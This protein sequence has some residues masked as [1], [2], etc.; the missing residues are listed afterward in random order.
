MASA[1]DAA[2]W[3]VNEAPVEERRILREMTHPR[4][5]SGAATCI[6]PY[7]ERIVCSIMSV[8][9]EYIYTYH[10]SMAGANA[11]E[12]E[13]SG[14]SS[15]VGTNRLGGVFDLLY[16][17]CKVR[18]Y[19]IVM[20]FFPHGVADVEPVFA[21]LWQHSSRREILYNLPQPA[22]TESESSGKTLVEQW[23]ELGKF[24]L[25]RPGC[26][27]EGAAVML[28]RLLSRKDTADSVQPAFINWAVHEIRDA[29]GDGHPLAAAKVNSKKAGLSIASVLRVNGALRVLCHLF[30]VIDSA[31]ALEQQM[32]LLT[33]I[34]QLDAFDQHSLTGKL[35]TKAVQRLAILMLPPASIAAEGIVHNTGNAE[36]SEE[37]ELFIG[38]LLQKLHDKDTIVRWSAAKGVGRVAERLPPV[39]AQEIVLAVASILKEEALIPEDGGLIDVS[40]T[41]EFSWHG[42]LLA[43]AELSRKGLLL[44]QAL[45]EIVPWV[46]RGLTYEI[47][48]GDYSVGSNVRDAACYV[49]WSFA[50]SPNPD[51]RNVF[52]EMSTAMA[53]TLISVAV[54]DRESNVRRAASAAFQEHVGRHNSFLMEYRHNLPLGLAH[55]RTGSCCFASASPLAPEYVIYNLLPDIV[56]NTLSPFLAVR[57]GAIVATGVIAETIAPT[58]TTSEHIQKMILSVTSSL[59]ARYT[60]D[61]GAA[62]TLEALSAYMGS[63]SRAKWSIGG[64]EGQRKYFDYFTRAFTVCKEAQCLVSSF[65][66]FVDA[67]GVSAEQHDISGPLP[68]LPADIGGMVALSERNTAAAASALLEGLLDHAVDNRGDVGSWVRK[69]C[70]LSLAGMFESD[71]ALLSKLSADQ[72]LALCLF[73][74]SLHAATEKIDKIRLAAG[75]LIETLLYDQKPVNVDPRIHR[76]LEQL[77]QFI[78]AGLG[79]SERDANQIST[80]NSSGIA[81]T[82]AES[83]FE[84]LTHALAVPEVKLR[85]SLFEGL[86]LAGSAEPLH[87]PYL[88]TFYVVQGKYA[89][90]AVSA[91]IETLP[92]TSDDAVTNPSSDSAEANESELGWS[93]DGVVAELTR[94]LLTDRRT[95][96]IIN[97][98][99]I[100]ADQLIEQGSLQPASSIMWAPI[101]KAVQRVAFKLRAPQR[102][103][104]CL[105]LYS[106][107]ALISEELAKMAAE[108]LL[109]HISHPIP[110]IRQVAADHLFTMLCINGFAEVDD[111]DSMAEIDRLLT[112]TEWMRDDSGV[113]E[114]R[115]D[116]VA[117]VRKVLAPTRAS[118]SA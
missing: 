14:G 78:P 77:K 42:A 99:L 65:S 68:I 18:G 54:F 110:K 27:M 118:G 47:Q 25:H 73:G 89:V 40:M 64:T 15:A 69:Q 116:L 83:T 48:R 28:S 62:L 30:A 37:V 90:S 102:L 2:G 16:T 107:M 103:V 100:V 34:F 7:L 101:Y 56:A 84:K 38:I 26:E 31:E 17:L 112:E 9:Q 32:P 58:L 66:S 10:D 19:K 4:A 13:T 52:G 88:H 44:T 106:S 92:A 11:G 43:L 111:E 117:L 63:V 67:F 70:L 79:L 93:V 108:S 86:V 104:L 97:P 96:R 8:I 50:R 21:T 6:D 91:Y 36:V 109:A 20:R 35:V 22:D 33:D 59:P 1:G 51:S 45:R 41:S 5:V 71:T 53:T 114:A 61:F 60:E 94:L 113:K 105:K 29:V 57:H 82:D 72:E 12:P 81:W 80:R 46:V 55:P 49:M 98:T 24:Y 87:A 23:V 76:C 95:S 85:Q 115:V 3:S 75:K 39:L 74:R